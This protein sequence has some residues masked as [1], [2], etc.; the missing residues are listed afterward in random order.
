MVAQLQTKVFLL[1]EVSE[2]NV[3]NILPKS[4]MVK[5]LCHSY[6]SQLNP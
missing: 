6:A 2:S 3:V 4:L 5:P 1:A